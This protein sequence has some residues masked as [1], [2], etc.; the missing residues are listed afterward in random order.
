MTPAAAGAET[1]LTNG[2]G[3]T[4]RRLLFGSGLVATLAMAGVSLALGDLEGGAVTVGFA[5]STLLV[6]LRRGTWGAI[7][8]VVV[9]AIT[10]YFML[11]AALTN[12][13]SGSALSSVLL[14]AGLSAVSLLALVAAIGFLIRRD[15]EGRAAPWTAVA[16]SLVVLIGLVAWGALTTGAETSSGDISL[17][18]ENVAFSDTDLSTDPGQVSVTLENKDLFWHTF[19]IDELGVDLRVPTGATLSV[20]FDAPPG[21]YR[22]V[23]AIPGHAGA[24]MEGTLTVE[25]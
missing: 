20:S 3:L 11:T 8:I 23:C 5:V 12:I 2:Q 9:S 4:W 13:R 7:G 15:S 21:I 14:T 10:L 1:T 25:S 19:T 24:G 16:I 6:R 17:I 18:S 22:F